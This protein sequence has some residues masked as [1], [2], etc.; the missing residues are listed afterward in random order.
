M[1][2]S[3]PVF[4]IVKSDEKVNTLNK[5]FVYPGQGVVRQILSTREGY[6]K[7]EVLANRMV[8]LVPEKN[9]GVKLRPLISIQEAAKVESIM[10][11]QTLKS[12]QN[13]WNRRHREFMEKLNSG[14]LKEIASVFAMINNS[15]RTK[16]LSFGE[17]K[18]L[19]V[20]TQL[21]DIEFKTINY[22][23]EPLLTAAA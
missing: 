9:S 15:K 19:Q 20:C 3:K 8:I 18:I 17:K 4:K 21:I 13:N 11:D 2:Q 5:Y 12:Q 6:L 10:M 22:H 1:N 16:E 14:N 7:F 23:Q